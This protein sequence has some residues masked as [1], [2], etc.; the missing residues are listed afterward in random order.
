[1]K[2]LI[3]LML[4]LLSLH[5]HAAPVQICKTIPTGSTGL[6]GCPPGS[7]VFDTP[8]PSSLVRS[9]VSGVQGWRML[10]TLAP[11]D[12]VY[13]GV[14]WVSLSASSQPQ[15]GTPISVIPQ[16]PVVAQPLASWIALQWTC[17]ITGNLATCTAPLTP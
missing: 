1:M 12:L 11:A 17:S 14:S 13:T 5:A 8:A 7:V 10:S 6:M 4:G 2:F 9:Q 16:P 15:T 3:G